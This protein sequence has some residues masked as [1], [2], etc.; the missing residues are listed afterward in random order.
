MKKNNDKKEEEEEE[1][2]EVEKK[3]EEE[4]GKRRCGEGSDEDVTLAEMRGGCWET[5]TEVCYCG[6]RDDPSR[7]GFGEEG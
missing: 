5:A 1:D 6:D 7:R 3:D 2:E 4:E